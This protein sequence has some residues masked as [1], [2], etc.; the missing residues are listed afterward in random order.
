[1]NFA[2]AYRNPTPSPLPPFLMDVS[3]SEVRRILGTPTGKRVLTEA[4]TEM[5]VKIKD[6]AVKAVTEVWND[7]LS[8]AEDYVGVLGL[9]SNIKA[10]EMEIEARKDPNYVASYKKKK[11]DGTFETVEYKP[12]GW[13]KTH[14]SMEE[15][16]NAIVNRQADATE[17]M[18]GI[19]AKLKPHYDS[20]VEA[21]GEQLVTESY[22]INVELDLEQYDFVDNDYPFNYMT[23]WQ[24][25]EEGLRIG[26]NATRFMATIVDA[27]V[28]MEHPTMKKLVDWFMRER[29]RKLHAIT[30]WSQIE[31]MVAHL[32]ERNLHIP[33]E[34][35]RDLKL[36]M[37]YRELT[38]GVYA[39]EE[40]A[41][42]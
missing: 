21:Y 4:L 34:W 26:D 23:G 27:M 30:R 39:R 31:D 8:Q 25:Y 5:E 36:M 7:R 20:F 9:I 14:L 15:I 6:D 18:G 24:I 22:N 17:N 38:H 35:K 11:A 2:P 3:E 13:Q 42:G 12:K 1:M 40:D 16:V 37:K 32:R 29:N 33:E 28:L 19:G 10:V 41:N